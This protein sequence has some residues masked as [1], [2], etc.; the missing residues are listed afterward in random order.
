MSLDLEKQFHQAFDLKDPVEMYLGR[1][2]GLTIMGTTL[3]PDDYK[4]YL[5]F[6]LVHSL[7]M[8]TQFESTWHP[9]TVANSFKMLLHQ[10]F[11]Y[12]HQMAKYTKADESPQ[13]DRIFGSVVAVEYPT[14]P[15][16]GWAI[17]ENLEWNGPEKNPGI[18]VVCNLPKMA[19]GADRILGSFQT[20][21]QEWTGSI[22]C[23]ANLLGSGILLARPAGQ[24]EADLPSLGPDLLA[25]LK[26]QTPDDLG[27]A[28][29]LYT[30]FTQAPEEL[31][32]CYDTELNMF[33]KPYKGRRC[34]NLLGGINGTVE[35]KGVGLVNYGGEPTARLVE[36][37]AE[38][39][40]EAEKCGVRSAECG[41][42]A[43]ER[44]DRLGALWDRAGQRLRE[45]CQ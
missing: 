21:R 34:I 32:K 12:R 26:K 35:L 8:V 19:V 37:L 2:R 1:D 20:G 9:S 11:N 4:A 3:T 41:T 16:G 23:G 10:V 29:Y 6:R 27:R 22:E 38:G 13:T 17:K 14:T 40:Q 39:R 31:L 7:P 43:A 36:I 15:A 24:A 25:L 30:G 44:I 33:V 45:F 28:G 42:E 5:E 18:R